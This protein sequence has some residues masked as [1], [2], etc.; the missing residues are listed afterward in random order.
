M[1]RLS[2]PDN[3]L[4]KIETLYE[5][6]TSLFETIDLIQTLKDRFQTACERMAE[7]EAGLSAR[8]DRNRELESAFLGAIDDLETLRN[9][10]SSKAD[11]LLDTFRAKAQEMDEALHALRSENTGL[12]EER[13]LLESELSRFSLFMEGTQ[14]AVETLTADLSAF[15]EQVGR[16]LA[17]RFAALQET[18][19]ESAEAALRDLQDRFREEAED[20]RSASEASGRDLFR[21][22]EG[23][24]ES[25]QEAL[26]AARSELTRMGERYRQTLM[27]RADE[28]DET[29]LTKLAEVEAASTEAVE[30]VREQVDTA[31]AA[32]EKRHDTLETSLREEMASRLSDG[33]GDLRAQV[34]SEADNRFREI[35]ARG[36]EVAQH[37]ATLREDRDALGALQKELTENA[38]ILE[39]DTTA[40]MAA[41]EKRVEELNADVESRLRDATAGAEAAAAGGEE[42]ISGFLEAAEGKME[43][44]AGDLE[45]MKTAVAEGAA[46]AEKRA[47]QRRSDLSEA[48]HREITTA[49]SKLEENRREIDAARDRVQE[50][51]EGLTAFQSRITDQADAAAASLQERVS[52]IE[53]GLRQELEKTVRTLADDRLAAIDGS[54]ADQEARIDAALSEVKESVEERVSALAA[55]VRKVLSAERRK[56][57]SVGETAAGEVKAQADGLT[58]FMAGAEEQIARLSRDLE[59]FRE[60]AEAEVR[61]RMADLE[62]LAA[63]LEEKLG[64]KIDQTIDRKIDERIGAALEEK[65]AEVSSRLEAVLEERLTAAPAAG[66]G[67]EEVAEIKSYLQK[68]AQHTNRNRQAQGA[69]LQR[70]DG[71]EEMLATL[72]KRIGRIESLL[73]RKKRGAGAGGKGGPSAPPSGASS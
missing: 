4:E 17:A 38:E 54:V 41:L 9:E 22:F 53:A 72:E 58:A 27:E 56:S 28:I 73:L 60:Q 14:E 31:L 37:L 7:R 59:G 19:T 45:R 70:I 47:D 26:A 67:R 33:I 66:P 51:F 1:A 39:T 65:L 21:R 6:V 16:D 23:E 11:A 34:D 36:E 2:D 10:T 61:D 55:Q 44:L 29:T 50:A 35:A 57:Q 69:Q 30:K 42:R 48:L 63:G 18:Q 43:A 24:R 68:L 32:L 20:V 8:I 40:R 15:R 13:A 64:Q 5:K 71:Q 25:I 46:E 62:G 3:A 52:E 12:E 49:L